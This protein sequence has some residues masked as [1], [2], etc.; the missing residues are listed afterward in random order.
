MSHAFTLA[1]DNHIAHGGESSG[2]DGFDL[3]AAALGQCLLNTLLAKAQHDGMPIRAAKATVSTKARLA[4]RGAAP[5][6]SELEVDI[7]LEGDLDEA[8]RSTL[9]QW[10]RDKCGVRATLAHPPRVEERV[11][12]VARLDA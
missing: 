5:R 8:E 9:E 3:I 11:H 4:V 6:L 12:V 7:H 1:G 10:A 2:P